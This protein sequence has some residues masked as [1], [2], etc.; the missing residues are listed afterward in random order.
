MPG[1]ILVGLYWVSLKL[2]GL[3]NS[4]IFNCPARISL[5]SSYRPASSL[6][7]GEGG[8]ISSLEKY[9]NKHVPAGE[10]SCTVCS[11][12]AEFLFDYS[13]LVMF[14]DFLRYLTH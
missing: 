7:G 8:G 4:K 9:C 3:D 1:E 5:D 10:N 6:A 13:V 12:F 14:T 11:G 2:S